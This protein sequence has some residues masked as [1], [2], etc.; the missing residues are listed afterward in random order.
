MAMTPQFRP[1]Q[2]R[3]KM[4]LAAGLLSAC[5]VFVAACGSTAAPGS[6][7]AAPSASSGTHSTAG[8]TTAAK[9]SLTIVTTAP[10]SVHR[11]T[12]RCDPPGGT[13]PDA[14]VVCT[15]LIA[16]KTILQPSDVRVMCPM[17]MANAA[18]YVIY[19]TWFGRAVHETIVDGGCDLSRWGQMHQIFN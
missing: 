11:W 5:G 6:N 9:A 13:K 17:I 1:A 2:L 3:S 14:A 8:T 10:G 15:Q 19:G 4:V 18:S 7:A 16:H 12:L